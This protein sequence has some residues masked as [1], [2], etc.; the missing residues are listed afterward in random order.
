MRYARRAVYVSASV[1]ACMR[2]AN[3]THVFAVR[4]FAKE[5]GDRERRICQYLGLV[6]R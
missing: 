1:P 4:D 5:W 3:D 6:R 2:E